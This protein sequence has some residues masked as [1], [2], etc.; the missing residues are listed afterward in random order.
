MAGVEP[1]ELPVEI[2]SQADR[3]MSYTFSTVEGHRLVAV[4]TNGVAVEE[5]PGVEATITIPGFTASDVSVIDLLHN[6]EQE[7]I[8]ETVDGDTLIN[9]LLV[10]DYPIIIRLSP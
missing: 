10:R 8:A 3:L 7:L 4:W 5:D 6:L 9:N 1:A 2:D